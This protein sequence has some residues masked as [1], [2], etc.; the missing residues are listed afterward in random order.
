VRVSR[1]GGREGERF[2]SPT[3]QRQRIADASKR[4]GLKLV[5]TLE[6]LDVSGGAPIEQR[7]ALS[8]ALSTFPTKLRPL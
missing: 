1:T 5:E 8:E 2:V 4:D 6:E 3:D 7:P